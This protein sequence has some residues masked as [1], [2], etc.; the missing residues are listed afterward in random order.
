[1][2]TIMHLVNGATYTAQDKIEQVLAQIQVPEQPMMS[3]TD[4]QGR[5]QWLRKSAVLLVEDV[6]M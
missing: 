4:M 1:M 6:P 2:A 3:V 5:K